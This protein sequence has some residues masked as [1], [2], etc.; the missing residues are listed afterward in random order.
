MDNEEREINVE[1]LLHIMLALQGDPQER[2][3]IVE[4]ISQ[5]TGV[6]PE[7]VELILHSF[8]TTLVEAGRSN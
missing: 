4:R 5:N 8:L 7:K 2:N 6:T 3:R 1:V